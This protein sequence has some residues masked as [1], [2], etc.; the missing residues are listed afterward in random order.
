MDEANILP[1]FKKNRKSKF[2][3]VIP[4]NDL[5]ISG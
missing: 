4:T 1:S 3:T 2:P 5:Q